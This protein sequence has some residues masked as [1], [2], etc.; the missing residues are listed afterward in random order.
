MFIGITRKSAM[1]Y[2]PP[3]RTTIWHC[4]CITSTT[5]HDWGIQRKRIITTT[6]ACESFH[7]MTILFSRSGSI[8]RHIWT[9]QEC[10][11]RLLLFSLLSSIFFLCNFPPHLIVLQQVDAQIAPDFSSAKISVTNSHDALIRHY[12]Y[13]GL[14]VWFYLKATWSYLAISS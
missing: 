10:G 2:L 14:S 9:N 6:F 13:H 8:G 11:Q 1:A 5:R 4:G 12:W 3:P 7:K